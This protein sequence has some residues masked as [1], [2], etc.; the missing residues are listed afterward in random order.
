MKIDINFF[1]DVASEIDTNK[2]NLDNV[3][4]SI[5]D[6]KSSLDSRINVEGLNDIRD[7]LRTLISD[8]E[9][10][11]WESN[12]AFLVYSEGMAEGLGLPK[13]EFSFDFPYLLPYGNLLNF[14]NNNP[15]NIADYEVQAY[16]DKLAVNYPFLKTVKTEYRVSLENEI[17]QMLMFKKMFNDYESKREQVIQAYN[18]YQKEESFD[19]YYVILTNG[20]QY[21][22]IGP[23]LEEMKENGTL[24]EYL[25]NYYNEYNNNWDNLTEEQ[26]RAYDQNIFDFAVALNNKKA[27]EKNVIDLVPVAKSIK[28]IEEIEKLF[29]N[30]KSMEETMPLRYLTKTQAF[31]DFKNFQAN[32]DTYEPLSIDHGNERYLNDLERDIYEYYWYELGTPAADEFK[33][34]YLIANINAA[35]GQEEAYRLLDALNNN[36]NIFSQSWFVSS[37]GFQD[38]LENYWEGLKNIFAPSGVQSPNAYKAA[39]LVQALEGKVIDSYFTPDE[40]AD[41][42]NKLA[43]GEYNKDDIIK[44]LQDK[45]ADYNTVLDKYV[46]M[47]MSERAKNMF[48][49]KLYS[50]T[51]SIGNM[52]PSIILGTI[53]GN[54][55]LGS[56]SMGVSSTGN[57][58]NS[59]LT[60]G[61][62]YPAAL[63]YGIFSGL[64]ET[65]ME[66]FLGKIPGMSKTL[67]ELGGISNFRQLVKNVFSNAFGEAREEALQNVFQSTILDTIFLGKPI[68]VGD[69]VA[70]TTEAAFMGFFTSLLM[71]GGQCTVNCAGNLVNVTINDII[72][73]K[74][75][76]INDSLSNRLAQFKIIAGEYGIDVDFPSGNVKSFGEN[77]VYN[78]YVDGILNVIKAQDSKYGIGSGIDGLRKYFNP[79][80]ADYGNPNL[81]TRDSNAREFIR[82]LSPEQVELLLNTVIINHK[83]LNNTKTP[84]SYFDSLGGDYGINQGSLENLCTYTYKGKTYKF[85]EVQRI[86]QEA[87]AQGKPIPRFQKTGGD[88]YFKLKTKLQKEGFTS[89]E[90]SV[91]MSSL[92]TT[93]ACS[94]AAVCNAIAYEFRN[95]PQGFEE[96]FGYPLYRYENGM[97]CFNGEELL[98]DIFVFANN[99]KNGGK[100]I[101]NNAFGKKSIDQRYIS[102]DIDCFGR[103][104]INTEYQVYLKKDL[105]TNNK[106]I[107]AFLRSKHIGYNMDTSDYALQRTNSK[108]YYDVGEY[109]NLMAPIKNSVE[110]GKNVAFTIYGPKDSSQTVDFIPLERQSHKTTT[111][112]WEGGGHAVFVTGVNKDGI[113]VSSWG[114]KYLLPHSQ[115]IKGSSWG[116]QIHNFY[117]SY[118][119]N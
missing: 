44:M 77:S 81:I 16:I 19:N 28:D 76:L 15:L 25:S 103:N 72:N 88:L 29:Q 97:K 7:E 40:A 53:T 70:S 116:F 35:M 1:K 105:T 32:Y 100:F 79:N 111:Y 14:N 101:V 104:L 113:I 69:L 56:I 23:K 65:T 8:N 4:N 99:R 46:D 42:K 64:S 82:K 95:N 21:S 107:N 114:G 106:L 37:D 5:I 36:E 13:G 51:V 118:G 54:P 91:I 71:S 22:N 109:N 83:L 49:S 26:E 67:G 96:S 112:N 57:A 84:A 98:L 6:I 9:D 50:S 119:G 59:A 52:T 94:Y 89:S 102:T 31:E 62:S 11:K 58:I 47:G 27:A 78:A 10:L 55:L 63:L 80:S 74:T 68:E 60:E 39:I 61:A 38:G 48:L 73:L 24:E 41:I 18:A 86:I 66:Y 92:D 108:G 30:F 110:N 33:K 87:K 12:Q 85:N 45:G 43:S 90:A 117:S 34:K 115:L 2:T 3:D 17:K 93:G 20:F 75:N